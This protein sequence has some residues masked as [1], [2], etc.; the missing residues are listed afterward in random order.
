MVYGPGVPFLPVNCAS[1]PSEPGDNTVLF[2]FSS[3][4]GM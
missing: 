2:R 1:Q 4:I 3:I